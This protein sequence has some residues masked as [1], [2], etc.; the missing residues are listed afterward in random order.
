[1][2]NIQLEQYG[3]KSAVHAHAFDDGDDGLASPA[4]YGKKYNSK[5]DDRDMYRLGRKQELKRRFKYFSIAGYVVVLGNSWEFAVVTSTFGLANGGT[6]GTIWMSIAVC[7]GMFLGVLS[8]AEI[9]SMAPTAGGQYHWVSEI[10][11]QRFQK[12]LS[13]VVGWM[14]L[15]GWQVAVPANAYIFAQQIIAL[16]SVCNP[17]YEVQGWQA[18]LITIAS[19][20]SAIALS[21]FVMQKLTLAEGLAVVAHCFGFVA[22][23]AI[24]WVMGPKADAQS[25]FFHFEN[26]S[27]WSNKGTATLVGIIGPIATFIGGDSAVHLAEELQDASYV[28]P[29]AMVTGCAINYILGLIGLISFLFNI[30]PI[31]DSLYIY[32]NEPWVAVIYRITGSKA[33]TIVMIL[34][35]AVNFFCL[36]INCV[37]TSSRQLWAFA[38]DKGV[39][40]HGFLSRVT[41]DGMPRNAVV[42]TLGFTALLSLLIIGSTTAF[43]TFLSFGN[44]GIMTSYLVIIACIIYRRFDGNKFPDTKFYL[45][46]W[47]LPINALA[48]SYL[49]IALVFCFFPSVP[50]PA[51]A[52]MN[53]ASL[54]FGAVLIIAGTWYF[55]RAKV[56]YD[57]PV[58]S[59]RKDM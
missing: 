1:M 29:R 28:L 23:L 57:G 58:E 54:M 31:D 17:S 55:V 4:E 8:L 19:A 25:T 45:G 11:P 39:P 44:A 37:M 42:V 9:A 56:E 16:I 15:L 24:L 33:A 22:F 34:V 2:D 52:E 41:P 13:Y 46:R 7:I 27:G 30:G 53:W 40:C 18:A 48:L 14:A 5:D 32:G 6:A 47:G 36:Q 3:K 10:A 12:Q 35:V 26:Q 49:M 51:P 43:N 21:V 20:T 59:V 38:R 50:H